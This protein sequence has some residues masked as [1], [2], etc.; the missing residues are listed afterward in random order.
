MMELV[1]ARGGTYYFQSPARVGLVEIGDG[2]AVLIDSGSDRDAAKRIKRTLDERGLALV[3][4]Y[5]THSHGD[6]I[7]GNRYLQEHTG[8]KAYAPAIDCCFTRYPVLEPSLLFSAAPPAPLRHKF[9]MADGSSAEPLTADTLPA[10]FSLVDLS[11]HS[12]S[13][14]GIRTPDDVLFVGDA[15]ASAETLQKYRVTYL[16]NAAQF[17][18]VLDRL[19]DVDAAL[20]IPAHAAPTEDL[21]ELL[22][23]NK[24]AV[25]EIAEHIVA[26]LATPMTHEMLLAAL[27]DKYGLTLS[28]AQFGL[29][30]AT[31]RAYL[32]WL[33]DVGRVSFSVADNF[34]YYK[35]V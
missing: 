28:F 12:P 27:F 10:G 1:K 20:Y 6:H 30:G 32:T 17:V 11:G 18:D 7:G 8:C 13:M 19:R 5:N 16:Y 22:E 24:A 25:L 15:V 23:I 3:A 9:F 29:V 35:A 34:L 2:K 21:T 33:M 31:L 4:I 14:V 26:L